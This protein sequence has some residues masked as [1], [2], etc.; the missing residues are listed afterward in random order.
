MHHIDAKRFAVAPKKI[1]HA[2]V[3]LFILAMPDRKCAFR[4]VL[5]LA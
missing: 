2:A 3:S 4:D 5:V 1:I